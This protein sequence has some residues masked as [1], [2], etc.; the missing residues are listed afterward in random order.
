MLKIYTLRTKIICFV[1]SIKIQHMSFNNFLS[2]LSRYIW[3]LWFTLQAYCNLKWIWCFFSIVSHFTPLSFLPCFINWIFSF[4]STLFLSA[5][6]L[7]VVFALISVFIYLFFPLT[8]SSL[9]LTSKIIFASL[10]SIFKSTFISVSYLSIQLIS[11]MI[12][13]VYWVAALKF[14]IPKWLT[15]SF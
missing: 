12:M 4:R 11:L 5:Y 14:L 6:C 15:L 7:S 8:S 3:H 1:I 10:F 2:L 9:S 13:W